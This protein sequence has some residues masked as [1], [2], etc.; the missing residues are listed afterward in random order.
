MRRLLL[1]AAATCALA[2][3]SSAAAAPKHKIAFRLDYDAPDASTGCPDTE[4]LA[5]M[6]A[7]EFGYVVVRTDVSTV[8]HVDVRRVGKDFE[9]ELSAPDP[10]GNG[11]EWRWRT[12]KQGTCRELA[13]DM[14]SLVRLAFGPRAWGSET[15]PPVL[16]APPDIEVGRP[17][18]HP[19][20]FRMP[21]FLAMIAPGS[22]GPTSPGSPEGTPVQV[23]A[24]LGPVVSLL[25]LPSVAV[26]GQ[27]MVDV[28]WPRFALAADMRGVVTPASGIGPRD[29]PA[30]TSFWSGTI[31][32]CARASILDICGA[33][34]IGR[35][36]FHLEKPGSLSVSDG[37]L[38][39]FGLRL[40][41]RW[42]FA[43]RY[44]LLFFGEGIADVRSVVFK[45]AGP[46]S[47]QTVEEWRA[48]PV[49]LSL[50]TLFSIMLNE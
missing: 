17:E 9:A 37:L 15:P 16:A 11:K 42:N 24:A 12:D 19:V 49:R 39:G 23:S 8:L 25:G 4:E 47:G 1:L 34:A 28:R 33:A 6:M 7:A 30:R 41:A 35:M 38:V 21:E 44:S 14:A 48:P 27:G 5:L 50:G 40:A 22:A 36:T 31:L 32:P 20:A 3:A 18:I 29:I 10:S 13:Y 46:E 43:Q 2:L 45:T 26:G